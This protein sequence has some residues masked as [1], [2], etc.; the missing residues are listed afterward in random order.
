MGHYGGQLRCAL[1][2]ESK[3]IVRFV[4]EVELCRER[5]WERMI[6][7]KKENANYLEYSLISK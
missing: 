4:E 6:W 2:T 7:E 3:I 1:F 5:D